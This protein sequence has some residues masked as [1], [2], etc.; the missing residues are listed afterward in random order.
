MQAG[1]LTYP[2]ETQQAQITQMMLLIPVLQ[3]WAAAQSSCPD[4]PGV[5]RTGPTFLP[6]KEDFHGSF[7][8]PV[9]KAKFSKSS[10]T[11]TSKLLCKNNSS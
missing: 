4:C 6:N 2:Q 11:N 1:S 7:R 9:P 8:K 5:L 10:D 3:G